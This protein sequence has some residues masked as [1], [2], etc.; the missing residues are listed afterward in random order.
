MTDKEK[1]EKAL[2]VAA[3]MLIHMNDC[4]NRYADGAYQE[5]VFA[6][7]CCKSDECLSTLENF[8]KYILSKMT[9]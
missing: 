9:D 5:C 2:D 1:L 7:E 6:K 3:D 4:N 8:K